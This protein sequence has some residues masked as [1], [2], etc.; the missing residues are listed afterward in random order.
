MSVT[1]FF[2]FLTAL[3]KKNVACRFGVTPQVGKSR[4]SLMNSHVLVINNY[5]HIVVLYGS[6]STKTTNPMISFIVPERNTFCI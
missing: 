3:L 1:F 4:T 2:S 6:V 5:E